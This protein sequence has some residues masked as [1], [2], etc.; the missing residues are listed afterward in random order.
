MIWR[1]HGPCHDFDRHVMKLVPLQKPQ[2][3]LG[4]LRA[5]RWRLRR[6]VRAC[7]VCAQRQ[8]G[9]SIDRRTE[10]VVRREDLGRLGRIVDEVVG[11]GD[12]MYGRVRSRV[13][14]VG[15]QLLQVDGLLE[16]RPY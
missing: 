10:V 6:T 9:L 4:Q 3:G 8:R 1:V 11:R 12:D 7:D 15:V 14:V 2:A 5:A 16:G 13:G